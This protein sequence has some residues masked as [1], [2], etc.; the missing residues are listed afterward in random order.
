MNRKYSFKTMKT[1]FTLILLFC[2]YVN[3]AQ[4]S[5]KKRYYIPEKPA[6]ENLTKRNKDKV[7][8]KTK[9]AKKETVLKLK[10]KD[11]DDFIQTESLYK[12]VK[13]NE[14]GINKKPSVWTKIFKPN[15]GRIK[16]NVK[17]VDNRIYIN[18]WL[19]K[20]DTTDYLNR[21]IYYFFEL[22]NRQ[23]ISLT[24]RQWSFNALSVPLK[25]RFADEVEF[26]TGANLGAL[27]GY[28]WGVT[29]FV[30]REKVDNESYDSKFTTG[31]FLGTDNLEFNYLDENDEEKV[32][33]TALIS[34]GMGFLY[35]YQ[36]FTFGITAGTDLGL[37]KHTNQWKYNSK[38]WLGLSLGYSLF[39][40]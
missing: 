26:S 38:P 40:F 27:F 8:L 28:T 15:V 17:F 37:G 6:S 9:L 3:Y 16:G 36:K 2:S 20:V 12:N 25:I 19:A 18:P 4:D 23:A 39:T 34:V 13:F 32:Q 11:S 7:S 21:D 35:S 30:F 10:T 33:R 14:I 22:K 1:A 29:K 24:F 31:V 5:Y